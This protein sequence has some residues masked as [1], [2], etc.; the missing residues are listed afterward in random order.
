MTE[1]NYIE[2][3]SQDELAGVFAYALLQEKGENPEDVEALSALKQ[4]I[5]AVIN[6]AIIEALPETEV[7][8]LN[9]LFEQDEATPEKMAE[10]VAKSGVDTETITE[11][12][13]EKFRAEY[14][15]KAEEAVETDEMEV[16]EEA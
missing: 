14:V 2:N 9:K 10:I 16:K 1:E 5:I 6:D 15:G 13:L 7:K 3:A 12:A 11:E 8:E 4:Q